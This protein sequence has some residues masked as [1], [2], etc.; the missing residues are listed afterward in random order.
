MKLSDIIAKVQDGITPSAEEAAHLVDSF[1]LAE[2]ARLD[3]DKVAA[4][5]KEAEVR[6]KMALIAS[7]HSLGVSAIGGQD[8]VVQHTMVQ[9]PTVK[10]WDAFYKY[11]LKTKDFSL[12]ER[13]PGKAAIKERWSDGKV[14]PGIEAFPVDKLSFSKVKGA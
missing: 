12:L 13:R 14:V 6:I 1:K 2:K 4:S 3:A 11:V 9:E 8:Y 7:L 5:L 10:D